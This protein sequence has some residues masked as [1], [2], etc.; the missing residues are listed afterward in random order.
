VEERDWDYAAPAQLLCSALALEADVSAATLRFFAWAALVSPEE[1]LT[2]LVFGLALLILGVHLMR[3]PEEEAAL[4]QLATWVVAEEERVAAEHL[5]SL[6]AQRGKVEFGW[7]CD[8]T[9]EPEARAWR[10]AIQG[11]KPAIERLPSGPFRASLQRL[12]QQLEDAA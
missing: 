11:W 5:A 3:S 10:A 4:T 7:L 1:G 8:L 6:R 2:R 9:S 12:R